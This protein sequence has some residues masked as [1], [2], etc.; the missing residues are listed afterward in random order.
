MEIVWHQHQ[1]WLHLAL[2]QPKRKQVEGT[3]VA[4]GDLGEV[5]AL[6]LSD[7][8]NHT[9][10]TGRELRSLHRMRN[11]GLAK[12]QRKISKKKKGSNARYKLI[13]RKRKFLERME[14]KIEWNVKSNML[15]IVCLK[16]PLNGV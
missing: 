9:L 11:K 13:L 6:T 15:P 12:L 2:E 14:R 5:H 4:G 10:L 7:G 1:Y 8:K 3:G 16:W